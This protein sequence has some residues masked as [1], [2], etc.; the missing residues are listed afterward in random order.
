ML[1]LGE[2]V[3]TQRPQAL[4]EDETLEQGLRQLVLF[5]PHGLPV[6]S[7]DWRQ[8]VGWVTHEDVLRCLANRLASS[9]AE[10]TQGTLAAEWA[11][12]HAAERL[13]VPS[14]RL[15]GYDLVEILIRDTSV[16]RGRRA[17]DVH[18]SHG[19]VLAAVIEGSRTVAASS[20]TRLQSGSRLLVLAPTS[21]QGPDDDALPAT[22]RT[23][24]ATEPAEPMS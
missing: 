6:L 19:V 14:S 23:P 12:P 21:A 18:L 11:A 16:E 1:G 17:S 24:V 4:L 8:V 3:G 10:T 5:G 7:S 13:H 2:V 9:E 20:D 15:E 22:A